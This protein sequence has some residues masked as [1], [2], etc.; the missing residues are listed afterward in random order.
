M[1]YVIQTLAGQEEI[2]KL[3]AEKYLPEDSYEACRILYY[4]RKK[5][6]QGEWHEIRERLLPGYLFLVADSPWPAWE[7]LK[8]VSKFS[9]ILRNYEENVIYPVSREEE[10]FLKKLAGDK[11]EVELSY[12]MIE[13]DRVRIISGSLV[14]ME[15]VIRKVDRHKRVAYIE[16]RIF[17]E[18]KLV[19]VGLEIVAKEERGE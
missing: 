2:V 3:M 1:W 17:G 4:I 8:K 11:D 14:G 10:E 6:Y 13:G 16:M 12:G 5:R 7:A 19:E 15:A 18:I 9:K